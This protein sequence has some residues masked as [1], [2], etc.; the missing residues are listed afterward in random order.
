MFLSHQIGG[1]EESKLESH[2]LDK[3]SGR[4]DI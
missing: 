2:L 4:S 3:I 1:N